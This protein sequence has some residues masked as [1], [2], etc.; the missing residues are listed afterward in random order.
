MEW[1]LDVNGCV[2]LL[3]DGASNG[4]VAGEV[5]E[6]SHLSCIAHPLHL[7]VCA[8]LLK[9]NN[10]R[11]SSDLLIAAPT[12]AEFQVAVDEEACGEIEAIVAGLLESC[13]MKVVKYIAGTAEMC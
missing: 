6:V 1:G 7:V 13:E 3:R 2:K 4:I 12:N 8:I 11:H 9:K 5:L 10:K